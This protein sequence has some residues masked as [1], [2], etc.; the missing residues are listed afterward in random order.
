MNAMTINGGPAV[1][2]THCRRSDADD[3]ITIIADFLP[4]IAPST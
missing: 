3:A 4:S 2:A 1:Y